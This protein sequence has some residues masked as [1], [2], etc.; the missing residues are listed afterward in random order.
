MEVPAQPIEMQSK[1]E[2]GMIFQAPW[3]VA[4]LRVLVL[5]LALGKAEFNS[6]KKT[7]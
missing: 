2:N 4:T 3:A 6:S 7:V 5:R 1:E